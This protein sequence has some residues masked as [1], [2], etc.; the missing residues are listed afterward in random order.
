[1]FTPTNIGTT[2]LGRSPRNYSEQD[3]HQHPTPVG[4]HADPVAMV[5]TEERGRQYPYAYP[6]DCAPHAPWTYHYARRCCYA[7]LRV[8]PPSTSLPYPTTDRPH[9]PPIGGPHPPSPY[10]LSRIFWVL[11]TPVSLPGACRLRRCRSRD[12]RSRSSASAVGG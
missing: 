11:C 8:A 6:I 4:K 1:M 5:A 2:K 9:P 10:S 3:T 7:V 12:G